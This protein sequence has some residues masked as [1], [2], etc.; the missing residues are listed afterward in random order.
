MAADDLRLIERFLEMLAAEK[1][2][3]RNT[4]AA[5]RR[6]LDLF[7]EEAAQSGGSLKTASEK[8]VSRYL[9]ALE[10]RGFEA[11]TAA[12][13]LS[14]LR[15]FYRFLYSEGERPDN[16]TLKIEGP[17]RRRALPKTLSEEE[18]DRL[19][20]RASD[21]AGT[22]EARAIRLHALL[23][24]LYATGLRVSELVEMPLAAVA[25]QPKVLSVRGK[26]GKERML[27]LSAPARDALSAYLTVRADFL[28]NAPPAAARYLFP[29]RGRSG[30]L[31]RHRF[32]QMLQ[33]LAGEAGIAPQAVTP[34]VLRHAFASHLLARGA[35]LR[36]VQQLLGHADIS[37]TQIY[38][39]IL[40]ERLK[41]VMAGHPLARSG[42]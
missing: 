32:L 5:Y 34:H 27:P 7:A 17:K 39:H 13:R 24:M 10:R 23:E 26:G 22:G 28:K 4:L 29:S 38:T 18:V 2:R 3:G 36:A 19:L 16:P 12:R 40:E 35:D 41:T 11:S 37:T 15:Q 1:G 42:S 33:Q 6:D 21:L 20:Q 25:G 14:A 31:T 9:A 30:H 8:T